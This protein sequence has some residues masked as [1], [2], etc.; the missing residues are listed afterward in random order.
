MLLPTVNSCFTCVV[1]AHLVTVVIASCCNDTEYTASVPVLHARI[2]C[3]NLRVRFACCCNLIEST[4]SESLTN[5]TPTAT[6][7]KA[8]V[9][10]MLEKKQ[11]EKQPLTMGMLVEVIVTQLHE[12]IQL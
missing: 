6:S 4:W 8:V 5:P 2:S 10:L 12:S 11:N 7:H 3:V 9:L 1:A